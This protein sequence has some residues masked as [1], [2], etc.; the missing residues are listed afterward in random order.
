ML[1]WKYLEQLELLI[2]YSQEI[3]RYICVVMAN[4]G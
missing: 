1:F 3:S 4:L 2:L